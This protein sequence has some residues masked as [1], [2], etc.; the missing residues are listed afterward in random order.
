MENCVAHNGSIVP[1]PGRDIF[2]QAW[3]QGGI[4]VI[5][6]TDTANPVEIAYFDR[7]P[8]DP[9]DLII[10]GYWSAYWYH[11]HIYG[12]EIVRGLDVFALTPSDYLS[13]AEIAAAALAD[14]GSVFNPQQQFRVTWPD[15]PIVA[16][17]YLDQLVRADAVSDD[18]AA[19]LGAALDEATARFAG[20]ERDR[21]LAKRL[22][23]L[24][25]GLGRD[26]REGSLK[27]AL[28]GVSK[29]LTRG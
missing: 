27:A 16:R 14:Q 19:E 28:A 2:V 8:L 9:E 29:A 18:F 25:D 12:T 7:G 22:D 13:E 11:G 10:G 5:D 17:A 6:F 24:A 3:Y 21:T 26:G 4:S 1:V 15:H 20:G 23:N